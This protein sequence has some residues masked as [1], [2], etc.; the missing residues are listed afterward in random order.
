MSGN[1]AFEVDVLI[2][3]GGIAGVGTAQAAAAAGHSVLL[4]EQNTIASATSSNSTKLIHG[5]LRYLESMQMGLVYEALREREL[6]LKL[7]PEL[8]SRE[9]FYIPVYR[10]NKRPAW[11]VNIGLALYW[12]LSAGRSRFKSIPRKQW[13]AVIPG[14]NT[15]HMTALL[16][17]EDA[18]TDDALLTEA[19]ARS[20][21]HLGANIQQHTAFI[22]AEF[23][24]ERW[25]IQLAPEGQDSKAEVRAKVLINATG[26]WINTVRDQITPLPPEQ[27]ISLVQGAHLLLDRPCPAFIYVE[28]ED[29]RVMFFRP[30]K[31]GTLA[32][33]TETDFCGD[34]SKV[35]ASNEEVTAILATYNRY[36]P[37]NP[38]S[39]SDILKYYCGIRVLPQH[40]DT[41]FSA[42]RSAMLTCDHEDNPSYIAIYGGK[43]TTYRK[44]AEKVGRLISRRLPAKQKADTGNIKLTR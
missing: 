24:D 40:S 44:K 12:V 30:W 14:L 13:H 34:P 32:G 22:S 18:A 17:Y 29:S 19:V 27:N 6:L 20:A 1:D 3:G 41:A 28:S 25:L 15:E 10:Y 36:F 26:P 42:S 37:D 11:M 5:G 16:A 9:L 38:C 33:T 8:V 21:E 7:A 43:L 39:E 35:H 4:V 2:I 23:K 31:G